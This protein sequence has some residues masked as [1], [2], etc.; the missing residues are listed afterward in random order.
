VDTPL[1]AIIM[2]AV[3]KV[4][5][6]AAAI[7]LCAIG[8]GAAQALAAPAGT[9]AQ[10]NFTPLTRLAQGVY[11]YEGNGYLPACSNGL[12]YAC[13]YETYGGRNCG[14]WPGGDHPACPIG[15][16]YACPPD[17]RGYPHCACW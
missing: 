9:A 6:A 4:I 7:G 5:V 3:V 10:Q 12:L 11:R 8:P 1:E 16:H 14:C 13:F 2:R 17:A 15:Y